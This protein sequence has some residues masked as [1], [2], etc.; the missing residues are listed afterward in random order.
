MESKVESLNARVS[1]DADKIRELEGS[2]ADF[3]ALKEKLN[4]EIAQKEELVKENEHFEVL[5]AELKNQKDL[6]K[7][8]NEKNREAM[9]D[10]HMSFVTLKDSLQGGYSILGPFLWPYVWATY[11]IQ[12]F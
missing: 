8:E 10:M 9:E 1:S 6:L 2:L 3:D 7:S 5:C 11:S 4:D 12:L